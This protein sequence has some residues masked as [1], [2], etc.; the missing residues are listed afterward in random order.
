M[1][2]GLIAL[3]MIIAAM[4]ANV[5]LAAPGDISSL[6]TVLVSIAADGTQADSASLDVRISADGRYVTLRSTA[7]NLVNPPQT[8]FQA[9]V[10]VRD[11]VAGVTTLI[12]VAPGGSRADNNSSS[13]DISADGRYV[14]FFSDATN[15][16]PFSDNNGD[17]IDT[18]TRV[19][20]IYVHDRDT[21]VTELASVNSDGLPANAASLRPAINANGRIV[22]FSSQATNLDANKTTSQFDVFLRNL[23]TGITTLVSINSAGTA[24]GVSL[25]DNSSISGDGRLVAFQSDANDLVPVDTNGF[26][27]IFVRDTTNGV[28]TMVSV[29]TGGVQGKILSSF[30]SI[31]GDGNSVAFESR[32]SNL[33]PGDT[34]T[35]LD[36]FVRDRVG[37]T[38]IKVSS[39]SVGVAFGNSRAPDISDDGRYVVYH[40]NAANLVVGD[41]NSSEDVFVYDRVFGATTRVSVDSQ[42]AEGGCLSTVTPAQ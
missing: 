30:A 23:N 10:F 38:T 2:I 17:P 4:A 39:S 27:D 15:M 14:T 24:S 31:S 8:D 1:K 11:R 7:Q 34:A 42:G 6:E 18:S 22:A 26:T 13:P 3:V 20:R 9:D 19:F 25:S 37:G 35:W 12:N 29:T 40:S 28:T 33:V 21:G 36:V 41:S 32:A 16:G 5:A